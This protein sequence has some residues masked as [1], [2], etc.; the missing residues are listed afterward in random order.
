MKR[1]PLS[2]ILLF[3]LI[4]S[5]CAN[6]EEAEESEMADHD[7]EMTQAT[8]DESFDKLI[9]VLHPTEGNE[10]SGTVTFET[11]DDGT[12]VTAEIEGLEADTEHGFHVH[13]FGD[14][15][16]DDAT[17]AG[18][19]FN[20]MDMDH[21]S[22]DADQRH[23]GDLGN[24]ESDSDGNASVEFTDEML[25]LNGAHGILGRGVIVH[26][27]GDDFETQPTGDAGG[28]LTCGVIGVAETE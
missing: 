8:S 17:S 22:P 25:E 21:G 18:G 5:G 6:Q 4:I 12:Q 24:I 3:A 14:C 1:F 9:A 19:H 7:M 2:I 26:E 20:P 13:E 10:V 11:T 16:A 28:R 23:V 15:S 27:Q